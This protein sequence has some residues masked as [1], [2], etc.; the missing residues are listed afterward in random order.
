MV[1][2]NRDAPVTGPPINAARAG[3]FVVASDDGQRSDVITESGPEGLAS[4]L[5]QRDIVVNCILQDPS[6]PLLYLDE[7]DLDGFRPGSLI[8]DVSCDLGMG[9]SWA[10]PTSFE[11][12]TFVVGDNI[13]YYGV[14]HSPSY[15]WNTSTWENST[16]LIPFLRP[17]MEGGSAWDANETIRRAIEIRDGHVVNPRILAFQGRAS[18]APFD[19]IR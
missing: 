1:L 3:E 12:P 2:T 5:A 7:S 17:V 11:E 19:V 16:A 4:Y 10:R 8:V 15:L 18:D 14:D 13:L 6:A 9:F